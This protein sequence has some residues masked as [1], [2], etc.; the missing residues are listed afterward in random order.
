MVMVMER[1]RP[2][3][4]G[5]V[6]GGVS[7]GF[8]VLEQQMEEGMRV[9]MMMPLPLMLA[10]CSVRRHIQIAPGGPSVH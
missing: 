10:W 7:I 8:S 2:Q 1:W 9:G 3:G 4:E 6:E 5:E